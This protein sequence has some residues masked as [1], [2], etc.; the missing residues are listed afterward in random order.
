MTR[1]YL[2]A[3]VTEM[4]EEFDGDIHGESEFGMIIKT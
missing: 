1:L 4:G 2:E 3:V